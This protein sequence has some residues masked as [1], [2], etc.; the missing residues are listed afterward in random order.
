MHL[1]ISHDGLRSRDVGRILG[2]TKKKIHKEWSLVLFKPLSSVKDIPN[3]KPFKKVILNCT[4]HH[5]I[6]AGQN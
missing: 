4:L 3:F 6:T 5:C 2:V 1:S